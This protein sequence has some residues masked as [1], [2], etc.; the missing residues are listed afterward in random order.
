MRS[1]FCYMTPCTL[2]KVNQRFGSACHLLHAGF[3]LGIFFHS[4]DW[5]NLLLRN[6]CW[7]F[8]G[9]HDIIYQTI[10]LSLLFCLL[11]S[12]F[13]VFS[14]YLITHFFFCSFSFPFYSVS[15]LPSS[16]HF[17]LLLF[18]S[19]LMNNLF[20]FVLRLRYDSI[21]SRSLTGRYQ[22]VTVSVQKTKIWIFTS[23]K[24]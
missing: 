6:V 9:L 10:Q 21:Q 11:F 3:L 4:E 17:F 2:L 5:S 19:F 18:E 15:L 23:V 22:N 12:S 16:I 1:I 8:S 20:I 13:F 24:S 14:V 7:F